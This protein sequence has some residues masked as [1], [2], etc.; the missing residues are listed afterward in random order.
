MVSQ[1]W[2]LLVLGGMLALSLGG[3]AAAAEGPQMV[4]YVDY[5]VFP[6][7]GKRLRVEPVEAQADAYAKQSAWTGSVPKI[8]AGPFGEALAEALGKSGLF[9]IVQGSEPPELVLKTR[10]I[11]HRILPGVTMTSLLFVRYELADAAS[12]RSLW[13][14]NI[15]V[16]Y[17]GYGAKTE[18]ANNAAARKS[19]TQLLARLEQWVLQSGTSPR[20]P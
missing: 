14:E 15:L 12:G 10:I 4:P 11:G 7:S 2:L 13:S 18:Y 20:T 6:S 1:R 5:S 3:G 8:E 19:L 16:Q 9:E 17:H